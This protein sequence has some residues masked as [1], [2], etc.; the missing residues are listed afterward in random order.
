M[1]VKF[2]FYANIS[3]TNSGFEGCDGVVL[4]HSVP[5]R[6]L[7]PNYSHWSNKSANHFVLM[8]KNKFKPI[9]FKPQ[10]ENKQFF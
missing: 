7:G 10:D 4:K 9:L 2:M 1:T 5:M 6:S 3:S 8:I